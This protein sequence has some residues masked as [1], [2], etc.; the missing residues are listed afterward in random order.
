MRG[1]KGPFCDSCGTAESGEADGKTP[2]C[3]TR[4]HTPTVSTTLRAVRTL[5]VI[6]AR[7]GSKGIPRKNLRP[8]GGKPLLA[9]AVEAALASGVVDR[10]VVSTDSEEIARTAERFG[11]ESLLRDPKLAEDAVTLDPVIHE[12]VTRLDGDFDLVLTVQPTSPLLRAATIARIV[13]RF[14]SEPIDTILTA[15]DDTHL[16]WEERD[17]AL[18]PA[19]AARVNRQQLPQRFRETGGCLATRAACVKP[20][21]RIG[22]RVALE[23]LDHLEGID[24]DSNDDW[25]MAE[26]ALGRQRIAFVVIGN[27]RQGL[28]HVTRVMS[29]VESL[30]AHHVRIFA[31]PAQDLAIARLEGAFFPVDVVERSGL[32]DA[33]QRFG[34]DVV[35]HDELDTN[36]ADLVAEREAGMRVITL[37]DQGA[38]LEHADAVFNALFPAEESDEARGHFYGPSVYCLRE[39]FRSSPKRPWNDTV[40][41]VLLTF[42]GTDPARLTYKVL[43]ALDG[44]CQAP[45]TVIAGLGLEPFSELEDRVAAMNASGHQ[46]ELLRDVR[47]MSEQMTRCDVAFSSAGR[48]IY[49]LTHLGIPSIVMAQNDVEMKHTFASIDNGLL[50]LGR[51]TEVSVD[52]IRAAYSALSASPA[53]R[54]GLRAQMA[55]HRLDLGRDRVID[56]VLGRS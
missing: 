44:V 39:E 56:A 34:A 35:V 29:L 40:Q 12:A 38:G 26:A 5:V 28:G 52:A 6:P 20:N 19:Y 45:I 22:E 11:A 46:V 55:R 53:L 31:D 37:E 15:I 51:G 23:V 24:I 18:Q 42:G 27:R 4:P 47:L 49:E 16:C 3:R 7:G 25:L 2:G 13:A 9:W 30:S 17:G 54:Q 8:I 41:R 21:A 33:L 10:V 14:E 43:D 32:Q 48:T 36:E 1:V 50:F